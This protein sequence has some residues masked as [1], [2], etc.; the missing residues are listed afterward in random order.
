MAKSKNVTKAQRRFIARNCAKMT[1]AELADRLGIPEEAVRAAIARTEK[2][3]ASRRKAVP[4]SGALRRSPRASAL[5]ILAVVVVSLI[6]YINSFNAE[7]LFDN[8][9][10]IVD[11][12]LV[13]E[14]RNARYIWTSDY[15]A[16]SPGR[17]SNLYRPLTIYSYYLNNHLLGSGPDAKSGEVHPAGY[18]IVNL[19]LHAA[20]GVLVYFLVLLLL[21]KRPVA[22][23]ASLLFVAH[24]IQTE[25]V[26]NIV[27]RA[28]ILAMMFTLFALILHMKGSE[29]WRQK[30]VKFY[31][32][33]A[34]FLLLGLL[35]KENAIATIALVIVLDILFTWRS[36]AS[37]A[38]VKEGG[39][40]RWFGS[41]AVRCYPFYVVIIAAWFVV[42]LIVLPPVPEQFGFNMDNP[43]SL[44]PFFQR[45]FTAMAVLGLYLWR[46]VFPLTLSADYSF[47]QI[48][49]AETISDLRFLASFAIIIA[50][51]VLAAVFWKRN[52]AV[53]WFILFFFIAI[54]PVSNVFVITGTIAGERLLYMPSAAWCVLLPL[55]V[56]A[57]FGRLLKGREG[58]RVVVPC[59]LLAVV[60]GLYAVRTIVRNEDWRDESSFWKATYE[61]SPDSVKALHGHAQ[62]LCNQEQP[63][64]DGAIRLLEKA[65]G[66]APMSIK[67]YS[68]LG[69]VWGRKGYSFERA[70]R[71]EMTD[72]QVESLLKKRNDC[73]KTAYEWALKGLEVDDIRK[74]EI[75]K[76]MI[77]QGMKES[78]V[79]VPGTWW[80][81][82]LPVAQVF[83][84]MAVV[85]D[86]EGMRNKARYEENGKKAVKLLED[87]VGY[88]KESVLGNLRSD[89]A[90]KELAIALLEL[91]WRF[92][93]DKERSAALLEEAQVSHLRAAIVAFGAEPGIA[94]KRIARE[95]GLDERPGSNVP[96]INTAARSLVMLHLAKRDRE[97]AEYLADNLNKMYKEIRR[98]ELLPLLKENFSK[99]DER[100][101]TGERPPG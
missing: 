4:R 23:F 12:A 81:V 96:Q 99:K 54:A 11:N 69:D 77:E 78:E 22:L 94:W 24:P 48:P 84:R 6:A 8:Q 100:I 50:L 20:T 7:L 83:R 53:T 56:F 5:C 62:M 38:G 72:E 42:R 68:T 66:I 51:F 2:R 98:D 90:H 80:Q 3:P 89:F 32:F 76:V 30:R 92:P 1:E 97:N 71:R 87:A 35:S 45:E 19:M 85:Y 46:L 44:A 33:A 61:A 91:S 79:E 27:G 15:W 95:M 31:I 60:A 18:H 75:R 63:D 39:F 37:D 49:I 9:S 88:C 64:Y 74:S 93:E 82:Y 73:Y 28:D 55:A 70:I 43:L 17:R 25:A 13:K 14:P 65:V 36:Y 101:W 10:I 29:P 86:Y 67:H 57:L 26:T 58:A 21:Q 40:F 16:G 34:L 59:I 47:N 52:R 41:H